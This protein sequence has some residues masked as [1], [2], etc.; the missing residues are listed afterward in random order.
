LKK[1]F[2]LIAILL[3][4]SVFAQSG[5]F[6]SAEARTE[7][8]NA[9]FCEGD[10]IRAF[11]EYTAA[12]SLNPND[13]LRLYAGISLRNLKR[14]NEAEDYFKGLFYFST[15][16]DEG[17]CEFFKTKFIRGDYDYFFNEEPYRETFPNKYNRALL[18]LKYFSVFLLPEKPLPDSAK[19]I[20]LYDYDEAKNVAEF[21]SRAK[22]LPKKNPTTAA[23]LSAV[24][25]G[26]GKIYTEN[27]S[28]GITAFLATG[29]FY[30]LA[31]W[32]FSDDKNLAGALFTG[33]GLFFHVGSVYG[34]AASAKLFNERVE[35]EFENDALRYVESEDYFLPDFSPSCG[36]END[37]N[38]EAK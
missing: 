19:F 9:L 21:Y 34:S 12:L 18:K 23:L 35:A 22:N 38:A 25:P 16:G 29:L 15:L 4:R 28:D 37:A 14:F 11:D 6:F 10:Y 26:A 1:I 7:F 5:G 17:R 31:A 3:A 24:I 2:I 20:A 13:T 27:Y 30:G 32:K 33:V 8:A 36:N